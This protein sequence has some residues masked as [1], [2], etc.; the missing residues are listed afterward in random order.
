M[1]RNIEVKQDSDEFTIEAHETCT[2]KTLKKYI[3]NY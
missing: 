3:T 2:K 1:L